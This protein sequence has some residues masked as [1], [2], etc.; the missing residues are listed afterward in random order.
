MPLTLT[1]CPEFCCVKGVVGGGEAGTS[2]QLSVTSI[3]GMFIQQSV[4]E[5]VVAWASIR[6]AD[7]RLG[8]TVTV[9]FLLE[10]ALD[11]QIFNR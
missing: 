7:S 3:R 6:Q 10:C 5:L 4:S 8:E 11:T 9:L 1:V 2:G